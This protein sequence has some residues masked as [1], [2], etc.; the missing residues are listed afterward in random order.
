LA[1]TQGI[2]SSPTENDVCAIIDETN[3]TINLYIYQEGEW[4]TYNPDFKYQYIWTFFDKNGNKTKL[5]NREEINGKFIY[6]EGSY[7]NSKM[8]FNL[9]VIPNTNK[10]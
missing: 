10:S 5:N 4:I 3:K 8:Q 9:E 6:V 7:I 2:P 1:V